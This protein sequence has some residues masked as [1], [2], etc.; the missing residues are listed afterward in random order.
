LPLLSSSPELADADVCSSLIP[1]SVSSFDSP[2]VVIEVAG[3]V[4]PELFGGLSN[5]LEA[6]S[7]VDVAAAVG[8]LGLSQLVSFV[9]ELK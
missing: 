3:V 9:L 2:V 1:E 8:L 4:T 6:D 5:R 7:A